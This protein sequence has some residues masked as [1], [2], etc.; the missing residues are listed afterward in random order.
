LKAVQEIAKTRLVNLRYQFRDRPHTTRTCMKGI[1]KYMNEGHEL[2]QALISGKQSFAKRAKH[3]RRFQAIWMRKQTEEIER[4]RNGFS[5]SSGS[6][7][8]PGG[9]LFAALQ[10]LAYAEHRFG[11]VRQQRL[12]WQ[13]V[14][15]ATVCTAS[16]LP[17]EQQV[18]R[19]VAR[20][21][22]GGS[23]HLKFAFDSC[24]RAT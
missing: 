6:G 3:S 24:S 23:L 8:Q 10:N 4:I 11:R 16:L 19:R 2:L 1:L 15:A 14:P 18:I 20:L 13:W 22:R 17:G 9:D 12:L 21:A 5:G 7:S